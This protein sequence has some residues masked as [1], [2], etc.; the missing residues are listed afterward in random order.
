MALVRRSKDTFLKVPGWLRFFQVSPPSLLLNTP[1]APEGEP[2]PLQEACSEAYITLL[3]RGSMVRR[4]LDALLKLASDASPFAG[5]T[6]KVAPKSVLLKKLVLA[7]NAHTTPD[8]L[9]SV[10]TDETGPV[11]PARDQLLP[12]SLLLKKPVSPAR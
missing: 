8:V 10:V 12:E 4:P 11:K 6:T 2:P 1:Q 5:T 7:T 3:S 9:G